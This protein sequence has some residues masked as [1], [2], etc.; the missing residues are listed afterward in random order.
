M[1]VTTPYRRG[2]LREA[3]LERAQ[4]VLAERGEAALSLRELARDMGVS[5]AAPGRHF[6]NRQDL[7]DAL[8]EQGFADLHAQLQAIEV[9]PVVER[10][11]AVGHAYV[12]FALA[13]RN[14]MEVMFQH[15]ASRNRSN[16]AAAA[17][18]ALTPIGTLF[19]N[20]TTGSGQATAMG[21]LASLQG[22]VSLNSCGVIPADAVGAIVDDTIS[23]YVP[24]AAEPDEPHRPIRHVRR[25]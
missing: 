12:G 21:F 17:A 25:S 9:L 14:L 18:T 5:H 20:S 23:R 8:A 13:K 3:L 11:A 7:V 2:N 10:I 22:I 16:V 6:N 19:D 1:D 4:V 24:P 15:R